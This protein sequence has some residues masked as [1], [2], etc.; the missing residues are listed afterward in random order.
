MLEKDKHPHHL[1]N[2]FEHQLVMSTLSIM[3]GFDLREVTN[4]RHTSVC[5]VLIISHQLVFVFIVES[6]HLLVCVCVCVCVLVCLN[7][8]LPLQII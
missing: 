7:V 8:C 3:T 2:S 4:W 6:V 5:D 1:I